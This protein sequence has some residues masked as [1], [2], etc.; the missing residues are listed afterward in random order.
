MPFN[1]P[2]ANIWFYV[3]DKIPVAAILANFRAF[4]VTEIFG[5]SVADPR[6]GNV[7]TGLKKD[8]SLITKVKRTRPSLKR[9][10]SLSI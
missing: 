6:L 8:I 3:S 1:K 4:K 2:V 7:T 10:S 9:L 5:L